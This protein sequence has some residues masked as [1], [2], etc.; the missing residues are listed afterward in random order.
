ML[1]GLVPEEAGFASL[2]AGLVLEASV[3]LAVGGVT[4]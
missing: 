4:L 1:E 3:V 2:E